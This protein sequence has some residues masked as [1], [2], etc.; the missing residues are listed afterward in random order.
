MFTF[1]PLVSQR[2][3]IH[4]SYFGH[5]IAQ[6]ASLR[7]L[8]DIIS[9]SVDV[10]LTSSSVPSNFPLLYHL[11]GAVFLFFPLRTVPQFLVTGGCIGA[12]P[13]LQ[14]LE[15]MQNP[16]SYQ[17]WNHDSSDIHPVAWSLHRTNYPG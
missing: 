2:K 4:F 14:A 5:A 16:C 8:I 13:R 6:A 7:D 10:F 17:E 1:I 9:N 3:E 11:Q 12:R 15:N